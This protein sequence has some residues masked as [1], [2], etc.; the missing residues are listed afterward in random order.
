[1]TETA[2]DAEK[3]RTVTL[4]VSAIQRCQQLNYFTKIA[5]HCSAIFRRR[6]AVPET[7]YLLEGK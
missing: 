6:R 2:R 7:T 5:G 1:M 3:Q 4:D